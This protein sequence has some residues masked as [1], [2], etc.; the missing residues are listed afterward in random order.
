MNTQGPVSFVYNEVIPMIRIR[1]IVYEMGFSPLWA[2]IGSNFLTVVA[3]CIRE[4]RTADET[5]HR[6]SPRKFTNK[7]G[8]DLAQA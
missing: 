2:T 4:V 7:D 5:H 3:L 8:L 6:P 1:A